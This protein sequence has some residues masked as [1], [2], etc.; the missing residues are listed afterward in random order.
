ML[1]QN[2]LLQNGIILYQVYHET[3][4]ISRTLVGNK[5]VHHSNVVEAIF[6]FDTWLQ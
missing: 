6:I 3:S 4:N 2:K 5:S 1:P